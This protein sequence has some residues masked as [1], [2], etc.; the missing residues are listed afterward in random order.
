MDTRCQLSVT[1]IRRS[2]R[3]FFFVRYT[4]VN[5]VC[6]HVC[7]IER[8]HLQ[9]RATEQTKQWLLHGMIKY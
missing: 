2:R 3:G 9:Q 7:K 4:Y 8:V 5:H 1:R 6:V